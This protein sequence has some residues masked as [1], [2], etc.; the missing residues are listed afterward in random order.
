MTL[1]KKTYLTN[2]GPSRVISPAL[3]KA[4]A[5]APRRLGRLAMGA[6]A[7]FADLNPFGVYCTQRAQYPLNKEYTH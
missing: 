5:A 2:Q 1:K 4:M 7:K 6:A 3:H